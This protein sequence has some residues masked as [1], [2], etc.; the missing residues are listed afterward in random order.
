MIKLKF[1]SLVDKLIWIYIK[2][3]INKD[4]ISCSI[5]LMKE[6]SLNLTF[7]LVMIYIRVFLLSPNSKAICRILNKWMIN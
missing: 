6:K 2:L 7:M 5:S 3:K 1:V 4:Y